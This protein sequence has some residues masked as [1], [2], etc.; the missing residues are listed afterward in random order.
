MRHMSSDDGGIWASQCGI[1]TTGVIKAVSDYTGISFDRLMLIDCI[2]F[3]ILLRDANINRTRSTEAGRSYLE[4]C[5][6]LRQTEPDRAAL[7]EQF[8]G[9]GK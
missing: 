8:G 4:D 6:I 5:W 2:T 9:A 7:R 3:Y 1:D